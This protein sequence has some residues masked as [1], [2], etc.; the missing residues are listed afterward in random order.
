M[1]SIIDVT[2]DIRPMTPD[3]ISVKDRE[4]GFSHKGGEVATLKKHQTQKE[5]EIQALTSAALTHLKNLTNKQISKDI[6][7]QLQR[8]AREFKMRTNP[9]SNHLSSSQVFISYSHK[10]TRWRDDL[11]THLKPYLREGTI[12]AWSD[13]KLKPGSKWFDEINATLADAKVA[14]LLV[15]HHFLASE[16]IHEHELG[17]LLKKAQQG[18]VKIL[19]IPVRASSYQ[20]TSLKDL[21]AVIDP[22]KPLANMKAERDKAWVNICEEIE[23]ASNAEK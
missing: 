12:S 22:A 7:V 23:K 8:I 18:G 10:D 21:H 20:K 5:L 14:V 9:A 15:T 11:M 1:G 13:K 19:W 17:P 4:R 2:C 6:I 3:E 16:F